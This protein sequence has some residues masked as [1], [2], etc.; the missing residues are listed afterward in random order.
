MHYEL[1]SFLRK[2]NAQCYTSVAN[3]LLSKTNKATFNW[4]WQLNYNMQAYSNY[5]EI[6]PQNS[7]YLFILLCFQKYLSFRKTVWEGG[8][9]IQVQYRESFT[10]YVW[11]N[12]FHWYTIGRLL[13]NRSEYDPL[14]SILATVRRINSHICNEFAIKTI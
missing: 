12:L 1:F 5:Y 11:P 2:C 10:K 9:W 8:S 13:I 3:I 14:Y 6:T 7:L 4:V